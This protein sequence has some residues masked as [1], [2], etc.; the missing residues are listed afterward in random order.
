MRLLDR[1]TR[2]DVSAKV[3]WPM[4]L[5]GVV[6]LVLSVPLANRAAVQTRS[7]A[8]TR[9]A[10]ISV[11]AVQPL[12]SAGATSTA[13]TNSLHSIVD[14]DPTL[15]AVRVW[16]ASHLLV[17]SSVK[18][19]SIG[20][21]EAL[22]DA[23]I[24]QALASGS[25]WLV[26]DRLPTGDAGPATF[27][28]YSAIDGGS[29]SVVT[30]F[31]VA[32]ETL[33]AD[34]HHDW[35]WFRILVGVGTL[36]LFG[37]AFLSMREPVAPIGAGVAFYPAS[38]PPWLEVM[39]VDRAVA[40]EQAGDRA[41]DRLVG[42]QH[43]LDES[44][45][46]RLKAEGQLQQLLAAQ[47]AGGRMPMPDVQPVVIPEAAPTR[48]S[49]PPAI[50]PAPARPLVLDP[51]P[52]AAAAAVAAVEAKKRKRTSRTSATAEAPAKPK[53]TA[54]AGPEAKL[55][56]APATEPAAKPR[57]AATK[58]KPAEPQRAT[59]PAK[60]VAEPKPVAA[61]APAPVMPSADSVTVVADDLSVTSA[62]LPPEP[63]SV[64]A[65]IPEPGAGAAAEG[66]HAR[67][68]ATAAAPATRAA[69]ADPGPRDS[70]AW[71]EVIVIPDQQP[72]ATVAAP[73]GAASEQ[74]S[75]S[76]RDVLDALNRLV[77]PTGEHTSEA[78]ASDLRA[79][80]ARTAALKKPGSRERQ[81]SRQEAPED[82]QS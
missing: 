40:L 77:P 44:E 19:D 66:K 2:D 8:A 24:D 45:R 42:L 22:N 3:W 60:L 58:A 39:D 57:R 75:D 78:E 13:L 68:R 32:D 56:P 30:Q 7:D 4:A 33:L 81:E 51:T 53:R 15:R 79:R 72:A 35:L 38:V 74:G 12:T 65:P 17:A 14:A 61:S 16:D 20:S 5:V 71:P 62:P 34:V 27:Y 9:A 69:E 59:T 50:V 70:E 36:L 82:L 26:T 52:E 28:A 46:L 55:Q 37:L 76:D 64:G 67:R 6:A 25:T 63:A 49:A 31:E 41:K 18:S 10:A 80:L 11:A 48:A 21:G 1:F 43:R 73:V 54:A 23:D 29:G 47:G